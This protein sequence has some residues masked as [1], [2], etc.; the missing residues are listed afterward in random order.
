M[1]KN[2]IYNSHHDL[3]NT[4]INDHFTIPEMENAMDYLKNNKAPGID[5][6]PAEI[7]NTI[8]E[9]MLSQPITDFLN[10]K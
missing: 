3:E 2:Y 10:Y 6:I 7:L 9:S 8:W 4:I 1:S 5:N